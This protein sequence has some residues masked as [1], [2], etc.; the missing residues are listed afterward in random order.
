M[1][2]SRGFIDEIRRR[3][4]IEEVIGKYVQL[5]RAGR[6]LVGLCPFHGEKTP[7]FTVFP[8]S[9]SYYC[10][11]CGAGGDVFSFVMQTE[12]LDYPAAVEYLAK[13]SGIPME[14]DGSAARRSEVS[15]D[16]VISANREAAIFF[17]SSLMSPAGGAAMDYLKGKRKLT[18]KTI[19]RF[20]I[21][22]APD[23]WT[24]LYETLKSK[25]YDDKELK[26]A[27]LCGISKSGTPYDIFRNRVMFPIFDINGN[28]VAFS[29][30][31]LN[32]ADE[33]K[34]VN[35]SDTPAFRKSRTVYA[36]NFA[37]RSEAKS[38]ILCEGQLDAISLQQAGFDNAVATQGTAMTSEQARLIARYAKSVFIAY[39]MDS[40]GRNAAV[41]AVSLLS[42]SGVAARIIDWG[43][44]AKDP[45]EFIKKRG[46]DAFRRLLDS[47][48]G[49]IDFRIGEILKKYAVS[50][51]DEKLR[52]AEEL[53]S[54]AAA[55]DTKS[56]REIY[57]SRIAEKLGLSPEAIS[58]QTERK[59]R[60]NE[61]KKK[62][63]YNQSVIRGALGYGDSVNRD[64]IKFASGA[65]IEERLLA[66]M[67]TDPALAQEAYGLLTAEDFITGFGKKVFETFSE[68]F[69]EGA[70]ISLSKNTILDSG[71]VAA[72]AKLIAA[73]EKLPDIY[74]KDAKALVGALKEEKRKN[75]CD[76]KMEEDP[77][78]ALDEYI[79]MRKE[80]RAGHGDK[81]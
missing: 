26:A 5:K 28:V 41:K 1:A 65:V 79:R 64:R 23:G 21:G 66:A 46:A 8:Q 2:F 22:Y 68:E 27:F 50:L 63:E 60:K 43:E 56:E 30:R 77:Q 6:N 24:T 52:A 37:K 44:E 75:D 25:G 32:E 57:I 12:G 76:R 33:R 20:G 71:E 18:D 61:I 70:E 72:L 54:L 59:A 4:D 58:E 55:A 31:R 9:S 80:K 48:V 78:T 11:G 3:N 74:G 15:R 73:H 42:E 67:L 62:A 49:Q 34:Y 36:L 38:L 10:F 7:S 17:H 35:T 51:P 19:T 45:D 14:D 39:D 53:T 47:S 69:S 40:A 16:R 29:G 13:N 81:G